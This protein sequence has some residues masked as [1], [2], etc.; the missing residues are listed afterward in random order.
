MNQEIRPFEL[1]VDEAELDALRLRLQQARWPERETV[2]AW[3]QGVP[4]DR[5]RKLVD[6]WGSAYDWR[7]CEA[8][9]NGWGQYKTLVDGLDIHF[10]HIRSPEA[11]ALPLLLT[12]GWPGSVIEFHKV[13]GLLTNPVEHGGKAA[14]AF[15]L[16]IPSLP[17][18]GFSDKPEQSGWGVERIARAWAEIMRRLGYSYYVAQGGDWGSSVTMQL[19]VQAPPGLLGVH[20]NMLS[21][22][23]ADLGDSPSPEEQA[24]VDAFNYFSGTES[25]YARLQATRP[26]TLGYALADSPVGQAAWIY[27]KLRMW[28]DCD[29]E[30]EN[31]FSYDEMLDNI[32][33][34][35]LTNSGASSAR[36]Y[37]ESMGTFRPMKVDLPLGYSHFPHEIISPVRKWA[38]DVFSNIIHW[39]TVAKGGHFA[40]LEQP[41]LFVDEV[42]TCFR[43]VRQS[44]H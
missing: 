37:W 27:E 20:F 22:M 31:V 30:A 7:R 13:I 5:L 24:A 6:Y 25:A 23:P 43:Q 12:H 17:G 35:W 36:L 33:L 1:S 16:V 29:G 26:Q 21:I 8:M 19:G 34:Y 15:H 4:M 41:A 38:E 44:Q 42:R 40:A 39:N 28:S 3:E 2:P 18:F 9:L 14:D 10:L 11:D 32:M